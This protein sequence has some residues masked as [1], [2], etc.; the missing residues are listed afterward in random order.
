[1]TV[2]DQKLLTIQLACIEFWGDSADDDDVAWIADKLRGFKYQTAADFI[3]AARQEAQKLGT[4]SPNWRAYVR[5][6]TPP[7]KGAVSI[8]S[9]PNRAY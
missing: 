3:L 7:K 2:N 1:M 9:N 4:R 8:Q 5:G 6:A